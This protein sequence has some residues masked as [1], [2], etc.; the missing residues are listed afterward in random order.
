MTG[1]QT[2]ALPILFARAVE[3]RLAVLPADPDVLVGPGMLA[4]LHVA[5]APRQAGQQVDLGHATLLGSVRRRR[6]RGWTRALRAAGYSGSPGRQDTP[7]RGRDR[8]STRLNSSH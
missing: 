6:A 4:S 3:I 2:W 1:V 5:L 7:P 8:K